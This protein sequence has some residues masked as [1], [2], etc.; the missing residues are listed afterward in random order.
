[1]A[2]RW[3]SSSR[4]TP[5]SATCATYCSRVASAVGLICLEIFGYRD[6]RAREFAVELGLA[7]QL[8]NIIRDVKED[9][10]RGRT[11]LPLEDLERF[12]VSPADLAAGPVT[13]AVRDLMAFQ[14]AR[15][16]RHY[17]AA[18]AALPRVDRRSLVAARIM[19]AVYLAILRRIERRG[20][21]VFSGKVTL[22]R[23]RKALI[24]LSVW[25]QTA[26]GF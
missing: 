2:W 18:A 23:W 13:P 9:H 20:F 17:A 22:P 21:D 3:T 11:Y 12:G 10:E 1:M 14:C 19:G 16:R 4:A 7:L 5:P 15:A 26:V 25:A 6:P 8:T 24:A